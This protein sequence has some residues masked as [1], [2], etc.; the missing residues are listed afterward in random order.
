MQCAV[1]GSNLVDVFRDETQGYCNCCRQKVALVPNDPEDSRGMQIFFSYGHDT[2]SDFVLALKNRIELKTE[3]RIRVWIDRDRLR[4]N[5]HWRAEIAKGIRSSQ[6]VVAFL[7]QHSA[8]EESVCQDELAIAISCKHGMIRSVLLQ[9]QGSFT[10]PSRATEYQWEDMSD[11][12]TYQMQGGAVWAKY[13]DEK[14][15]RIIRELSS[16]KIQRYNLDMKF[17][18]SKLLVGLPDTTTRLDRL[19]EQPMVG[20]HWVT[21]EIQRWIKDSNGKKLMVLYGKPGSGKSMYAAHLQY[22]NPWVAAALACDCQSKEYSDTDS[23]TNHLAYRLAM[24]LPDFR[25]TLMYYYSKSGFSPGKGKDRFSK[26][27]A[28]PLSRRNINGNR[29][30]MVILID[31]LDE[32]ETGNLLGYLQEYSKELAP[33]IRLLITARKEP[34]ILKAFHGYPYIDYD[35]WQKENREDHLA[36]YRQRLDPALSERRAEE[37]EALY[38]RL[39]DCGEGVFF[40]ASLVCDILT[41]ELAEDPCM[42]L[43][44]Y[45]L[46]RG[47]YKMLQE[48]LERKEFRYI[49]CEGRELNFQGFWQVPLGMILASPEPLPI[50]TLK[51]LMNWGDNEYTCFR[52]P[53]STLLEE[54]DG[55]LKP[56]HRSFGEW[57]SSPDAQS[58]HGNRRSYYTSKSDGLR[59]LAQ[60]AF[61]LY[62]KGLD[63]LD[64]FL[65][66]HITTLLMQ[67]NLREDYITVK[68]DRDCMN[69]ILALE[70]KNRDHSCFDRSLPLARALTE[71][72]RDTTDS[73]DKELVCAWLDRVGC[74]YLALQLLQDAEAAFSQCL[75]LSKQLVEDDPL[76]PYYSRGLSVA[77]NK[78]ADVKKA[79]NHLSEAMVLYSESFKIAKKLTKEHPQYPLY[80]WDLALTL[81][82]IAD[83][84]ME[85]LDFLGAVET[86][87]KCL[88][89]FRQLSKEYPE[90]P[91]HRRAPAVPLERIADIKKMK[92]DLY[93][94]K[95]LYEESLEIHRHL[96]KEHPMNPEYRRV[97]SASLV[98]IADVKKAISDPV[99][100]ME[101]YEEALEI[102]R[103]LAVE[104]SQNPEYRREL[105]EVIEQIADMKKDK[106][107]FSEAMELYNECIGI[108][109]QLVKEYPQNPQYRWSLSLSLKQI[110]D[111]KNAHQALPPCSKLYEEALEIRKQLVKE[112]PQ[113]LQYIEGLALSYY[114]MGVKKRQ[115]VWFA[116]ARNTALKAPKMPLCKEILRRLSKKA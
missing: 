91:M 82:R 34:E 30:T 84:K 97:L 4:V 83:V 57:L 29:S 58:S 113:N 75:D 50:S 38:N 60:A 20:R 69:R 116:L 102:R 99:G 65:L 80:R 8:R 73:Y 21:E 68:N 51:S 9:S 64:D 86:Y 6:S 59:N 72:I 31:G 74:N 41:E 53:F 103:Q 40:Y 92:N 67:A 55:V 62:T 49:D 45:P 98:S 71:Q 33:W 76:D 66:Y 44:T 16:D 93:G 11:Y 89:I 2:H 52:E 78:V 25:E 47:L 107:D 109:R 96:A 108:R 48:T 3:G 70:A 32:V 15:D 26:L 36:Y 88:K 81:E 42:D 46:P 37:R 13:V 10:P 90:N 5:M 87:R 104:C 12:P 22:Y 79:T 56:F 54:K 85:T 95:K 28:E 43:N 111:A 105:S 101:L 1:C 19:M 106:E 94:A 77:L 14:A 39:I 110:A 24:R 23:I 18:R 27:I 63:R 17:L 61:V 35:E 100:A 7:S 115:K 112:Y 114:N